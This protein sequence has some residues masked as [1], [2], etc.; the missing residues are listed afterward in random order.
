MRV[1]EMVWIANAFGLLRS[2]RQIDA[3]SGAATFIEGRLNGPVGPADE[4]ISFSPAALAF[5]PQAEQHGPSVPVH[6]RHA[7]LTHQ[8]SCHTHSI[9]D[10]EPRTVPC[11]GAVLNAAL[12]CNPGFPTGMAM[13]CLPSTI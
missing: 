6:R 12:P 2:Q 7:E 1:Q 13:Y 8:G 11:S 5:A 4:E 10:D 3:G 9:E